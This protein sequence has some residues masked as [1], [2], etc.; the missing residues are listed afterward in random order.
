[1]VAVE[2]V[3]SALFALLLVAV[4][5]LAAVLTFPLGLWIADR[6]PQRVQERLKRLL[7]R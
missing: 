1:M 6:L 4:F 5:L 7:K 2:A 3:V